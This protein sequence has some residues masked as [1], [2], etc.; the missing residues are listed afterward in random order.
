MEF[1]TKNSSTFILTFCTYIFIKTYRYKKMLQT[2]M[3][4]CDTEKLHSS[5]FKTNCVAIV[6]PLI[7]I[8]PV[9][10]EDFRL[11]CREIQTC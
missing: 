1:D 6:C 5:S 4:Q 11:V 9:L 2:D 3:M 7:V 8:V 10:L